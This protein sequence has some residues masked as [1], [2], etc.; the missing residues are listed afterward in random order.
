MSK[1]R[2]DFVNEMQTINSSYVETLLGILRTGN[3]EWDNQIQ[4]MKTFIAEE[5]HRYFVT[6]EYLGIA[7]TKVH[8]DVEVKSIKFNSQTNEFIIDTWEMGIITLIE[9]EICWFKDCYSAPESPE[10]IA[11][12]CYF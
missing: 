2:W 12:N 10:D 4:K 11:K 7:R 6:F 1:R 8:T 5:Y 3:T 9:L